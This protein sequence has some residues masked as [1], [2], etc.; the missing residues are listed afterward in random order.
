MSGLGICSVLS[1]SWSEPWVWGVLALFR[2][3]T[4]FLLQRSSV[5][6]SASVALCWWYFPCRQP[7]R[8][9]GWRLGSGS[10]FHWFSCFCSNGRRYWQA[11]KTDPPGTVVRS[12]P[13]E[14][15][16]EKVSRLLGQGVWSQGSAGCFPGHTKFLLFN[17]HDDWGRGSCPHSVAAE[18]KVESVSV[19]NPV[20]RCMVGF[21]A[22]TQCGLELPCLHVRLYCKQG[23]WKKRNAL[24]RFL[25]C[26][27]H[28]SSYNFLQLTSFMSPQ[29]TLRTFTFCFLQVFLI[30]KQFWMNPFKILDGALYFVFF[31]RSIV[32]LAAF[33]KC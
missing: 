21:R 5:L 20:V 26:I 7:R 18:R 1:E 31:Q 28:W 13:A 16:S 14:A 9:W 10:L 22:F 4:A 17:L 24:T 33:Q 19:G 15:A 11:E 23:N 25:L 2:C 27:Y 6:L 8:R 3:L 29:L 32:K 12:C 30:L